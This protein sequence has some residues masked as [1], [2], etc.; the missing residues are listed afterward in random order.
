MAVLEVSGFDEFGDDE[1]HL[2]ASHRFILLIL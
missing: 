1:S 2:L